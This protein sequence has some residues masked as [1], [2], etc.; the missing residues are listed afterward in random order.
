MYER[1]HFIF[2]NTLQDRHSGISYLNTTFIFDLS[3][4]D[5]ILFSLAIERQCGP[6]ES[7]DLAFYLCR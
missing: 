6:E 3:I 4:E 2:E 5:D 1:A 7:Q